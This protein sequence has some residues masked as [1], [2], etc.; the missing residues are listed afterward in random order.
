[1]PPALS[2]FKYHWRFLV[3][4]GV[5]ILFN[6]LTL[7]KYPKVHPDEGL[8][9]SFA[10]FLNQNGLPIIHPNVSHHGYFKD[11][12][13]FPL[14]G[15][16]FYGSLAL[17]GQALDFGLFAMRL[18]PLIFSIISIYLLYRIALLIFKDQDK[19]DLTAF[20]L[21]ASSQFLITAHMVRQESMFIACLLAIFFFLLLGFTQTRELYLLITAFL[22]GISVC[23]HPNGIFLPFFE[24]VGFV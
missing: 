7:T 22:A 13:F 23:I 14:S 8:L 6:L 3:L 16:L 21:A 12:Y 10:Y 9:S 4:L 2:V 11:L 19:A 5:Y 18:Q 17:I 15:I 20:L 24:V 1:M